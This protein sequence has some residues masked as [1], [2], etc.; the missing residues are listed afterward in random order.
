MR[1]P[2]QL[3]D[4]HRGVYYLYNNTYVKCPVLILISRDTLS[5]F[6]FIESI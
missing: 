5:Y 2:S 1:F 6:N 3:Y 4:V